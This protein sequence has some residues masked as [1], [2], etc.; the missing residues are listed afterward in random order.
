MITVFSTKKQFIGPWLKGLNRT[1]YHALYSLSKLNVNR[2]EKNPDFNFDH[3]HEQL[4]DWHDT[5]FPSKET[6][7]RKP[8]KGLRKV[9][10]TARVYSGLRSKKTTLLLQTSI[11]AIYPILVSASH[12]RVSVGYYPTLSDKPN[13]KTWESL[14]EL[15][16]SQ[17][18]RLVELEGFTRVSKFFDFFEQEDPFRGFLFALSMESCNDISAWTKLK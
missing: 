4:K 9:G 11:Q 10:N 14:Y 16:E 13:K 1:K 3:I 17:I 7:I 5:S 18:E 12:N 15:D 8:G 6:T 2:L